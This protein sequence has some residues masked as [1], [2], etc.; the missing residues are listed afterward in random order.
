M[1]D[2]LHQISNLF[3]DDEEMPSILDAYLSV[4]SQGD[5]A[6]SGFLDYLGFCALG[7][8]DTILIWDKGARYKIR[9]EPMH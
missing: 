9:E 7:D 2:R 3:E 4:N 6:Q 5:I 8:N 1:H